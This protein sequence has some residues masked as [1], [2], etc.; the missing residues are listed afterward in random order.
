MVWAK[1]HSTCTTVPSN[2]E[3]LSDTVPLSLT[4]GSD[5]VFSVVAQR[6][7]EHTREKE[8]K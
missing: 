3:Y 7:R 5:P 8:Y 2:K 4:K 6:E 1:V